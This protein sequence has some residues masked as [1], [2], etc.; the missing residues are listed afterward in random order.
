MNFLVPRSERNVNA[1]NNQWIPV[2]ADGVNY[3]HLRPHAG[4]RSKFTGMWKIEYRSTLFTDGAYSISHLWR[5]KMENFK[6]SRWIG[7]QF[8]ISTNAHGIFIFKLM[9]KI[10]STSHNQRIW[11][12]LISI[13][14]T[15]NIGS[16]CDWNH[17]DAQR[18]SEQS[19]PNAGR[20]EHYS[21]N[22]WKWRCSCDKM[23]PEMDRMRAFRRGLGGG[24]ISLI[25]EIGRILFIWHE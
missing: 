21:M 6:L 25:Y 3:F 11:S 4:E 2:D 10:H 8:F 17:D 23:W 7:A 15:L 16:S 5:Q 20:R 9:W 13:A 19:T 18:A 14:L 22:I 24:R 12:D 1:C